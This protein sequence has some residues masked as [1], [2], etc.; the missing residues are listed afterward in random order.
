MTSIL[1]RRTFIQLCSAGAALLT[2]SASA[3]TPAQNKP[4]PP[5]SRAKPKI[6]PRNTVAIQ[7]RG[8]AWVDE[9][10]DQVLDN[11][12][13]KGNVNTVWAY[14][15]GYGE[16]RLKKGGTYPDHGIP[17]AEGSNEVISG[18]FYDYDQKYFRNT[19]IRDFRATQYGKFNV[20][21]QVAPKAKARGMEF[22]A[23]ELNN[24]SP[25]LAHSVPNYMEV[26]EIDAWG[27]RTGNPCFNHPDYRAFLSGK[28]EAVLSYGDLIDG[29]AWG[30]ERSG[31]LE[32]LL[33]GTSTT[34]CFC[35]FCQQ[36]ARER[37]IS[38]PR[39]REAYRQLAQFF[40]A[41]PNEQRP[42]DG[43]FVTF[44]RMLLQYPE[45]LSW[46]T[47]WTDS[48]QEVRAELYGLSKGI[49]PASPFGF[50]LM[51]AM[52]FSP[53][54]RAEEDYTKLRNN[55]DFLKIATYNNAGGPRLSAYLGHLSHTLFKD[56]K[57]QDFL[58]LYYK[59]M[60]FNEAPYD[61]LAAS[62][63]TPGYVVEETR[64][65]LIGVDGQTKIWPGIDIEVPV[66]WGAGHEGDKRTRP[67]DVR[68]ALEAALTAGADGVVLSREYAE[69]HLANLAAA[70]D[71]LRQ[72]FAKQ[73]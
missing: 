45:I 72:I 4:V 8:F 61:Q 42:T 58:P 73:S 7:V 24:P 16:R 22:Y 66:L 5:V 27:R 10:I 40:E 3:Q 65:A 19:M 46:E 37:G 18:A 41:V 62:G 55:A 53:F 71:T 20:I 21:E 57:P 60:G 50:H 25:A 63:L 29:Y 14:V 1:N 28:V 52:T 43:Y 36:K 13:K 17:L 32:Y 59:M 64:R 54:F 44:W 11:I 38:V 9:G 34:T 49:A 2:R 35:P 23:W 67:E 69:M 51:Q 31:P 70:G 47:L 56:A 12:Q 68:A 33:G 39:A 6:R 15:F 48:Y 26:S 30:S